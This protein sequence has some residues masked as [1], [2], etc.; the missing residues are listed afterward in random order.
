MEK[1]AWKPEGL[2]EHQFGG[3]TSDVVFERCPHA[4]ED[5]RKGVDPVG[6][7]CR[8]AMSE[9]FMSLCMRSTRPF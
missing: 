3:R 2:A 5:N 4:H 7:P 6:S 1:L 8:T 9:A